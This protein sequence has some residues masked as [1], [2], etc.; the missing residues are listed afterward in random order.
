MNGPI[1]AEHMAEH[2]RVHSDPRPFTCTY[3][4]CG[5]RLSSNKCLEFHMQ[6]HQPEEATAAYKRHCSRRA[7]SQTSDGGT[8]EIIAS[9]PASNNNK[10]PLQPQKK[11]SGR[12]IV[13]RVEPENVISTEAVDFDVQKGEQSTVIQAKQPDLSLPDVTQLKQS[14]ISPLEGI[15]L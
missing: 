10:T 2:A 12:P 7:T 5:V 3:S 6:L 15:D 1:L 11:K 14:T 9:L 4:G 13:I 8:S